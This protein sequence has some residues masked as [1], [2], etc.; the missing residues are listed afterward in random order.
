[1]VQNRR[2]ENIEGVIMRYQSEMQAVNR[3]TVNAISKTLEISKRK[4]IIVKQIEYNQFNGL[5]KR[6]KQ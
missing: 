4:S 2:L 3:R 5:K 6:N 1:M